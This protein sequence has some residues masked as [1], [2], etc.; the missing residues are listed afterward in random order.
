MY[1]VPGC[2]MKLNGQGLLVSNLLQEGP[3]WA[4]EIWTWFNRSSRMDTLGKTTHLDQNETIHIYVSKNIK[5]LEY[6][7]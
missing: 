5:L 7:I 2:K 3:R 1:S 6:L 4:S